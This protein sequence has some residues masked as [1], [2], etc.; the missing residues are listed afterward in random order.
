MS[1]TERLV[2]LLE[3][4]ISDFEKRMAQAERRGSRT[5]GR[6]RRDSAS[7]TKAM[8]ADMIRSTGRINQALAAGGAKLGA[9]GK[10]WA[11]GLVGGVVGG[12][13]AAGISGIVSQVGRIANGVAQVGDEAKR[14]GLS[15][16]AFQEWKFV[17]EQNRIGVDSMVDALKELNLRA[18]E[19]AV[20]GKGS[21]A[22]AFQR[23]GYGAEEIARKLKDPSAL[24]LEIIGRMERMGKAAQIRIADELFGGTGGERFVELL[25]QGEAGIRDTIR[26]A[27]DL[28]LV[29]DDELIA[30]AA[31]V[32]RQFNIVASTVGT[33]LKGA[34]VEAAAA[35]SDFMNRFA[36]FE[37]QTSTTLATSIDGLRSEKSRLAASRVPLAETLATSSGS[38]DFI[39]QAQAEQLVA[40]LAALDAEIAAIDQQLGHALQVRGERAQRAAERKEAA[41]APVLALE[42]VS[43]S[44]ATS[45]SGG[46]GGSRGGGGGGGSASSRADEFEREAEAL[47]RRTEALK[48]GTLAQSEINPLLQDFG[49]AAAEAA[50]RTDLLVAA[51]QAGIP[52]TDELRARVAELAAGYADAAAAQAAMEEGMGQ[53]RDQAEQMLRLRSETL[54]GFTRDMLDGA[55]AT[56][57]LG[58]ALQ[59]LGDR[60]IDLA[61]D[62]LFPTTGGGGGGAG[63]GLLGG[64]GKLF[65]FARGTANTGGARGEPRGV[66]HGQEAVIPLPDGGRVPVEMRGAGGATDVKVHVT[67]GVK[68]D[69]SGTLRPFVE[70]VATSVS[71]A[72]TGA[73]LRSYDSGLADRMAQ[74]SADPYRRS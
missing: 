71:Q 64:I 16:K 36:A 59:R 20:T 61:L 58:S 25:D 40:D 17:A 6:L 43:V 7:A 47:E 51:Q 2:V 26:A 35:L 30:K 1:D 63:A 34:I 5:Y 31:E 27:N 65:G 50:A 67:T 15:A 4:K 29:M 13:A 24:I 56:D 22:E 14:A 11:A 73:A 19:F 46:G 53:R 42:P 28:G 72:T 38:S 21:A 74:I 8:E 37:R 69:K 52:I 45:G 62:S 60:L 54:K 48:A 23:L 57:A 33:A 9:V 39:A 18:D 3:A 32:D 41:D 66:V 55:S 49:H 10:A 68:L 70:D 44:G 12:L